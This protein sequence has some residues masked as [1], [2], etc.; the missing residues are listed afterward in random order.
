MTNHIEQDELT[1]QSLTRKA[2]IGSNEAFTK[3]FTLLK[4]PILSLVFF[5][6]KNLF[7]KSMKIF[8]KIMQAQAQALTEL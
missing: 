6:T 3:D 8:I 5:S 4:A 7:T 1:S 2:N